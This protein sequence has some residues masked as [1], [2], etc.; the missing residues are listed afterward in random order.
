[1]YNRYIRND[2]GQYERIPVPEPP[3]QEPQHSGF[4]PSPED[5]WSGPPPGNGPPPGERQSQSQ[6]NPPPP[7]GGQSGK[8]FLSGLL[9][10]LNLQNIDTGDL[11]LLVLLFLLFRE[12]EDEELLIAL[13][14]LLIM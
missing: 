3:E 11:L 14:L 2:Y 5:A 9:K 10:K 4:D 8:G 12:G 1:M 13:G 7:D 6:N